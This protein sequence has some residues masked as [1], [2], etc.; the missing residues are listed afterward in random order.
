MEKSPLDRVFEI[1][2]PDADGLT[3]ARQIVADA[4]GVTRQAVEHW[5]RDGVPG[6]H[7]LTLE[8]ACKHRVSM[9]ELLEWSLLR[10][11]AK[12]AA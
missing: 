2:A 10:R 6:K 8:T 3:E 9:R 1:M 7:V 12:A 11:K 4:C 5:E